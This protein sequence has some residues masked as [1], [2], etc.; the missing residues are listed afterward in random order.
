[1]GFSDSGA[2]RKIC[3]YK[4]ASINKQWRPP[5]SNLT[6]PLEEVEK[7]EQANSKA[8]RRKEMI[9]IRAETNETENRKQQNQRNQKLVLSKDEQIWQS[10]TSLRNEKEKEDSNY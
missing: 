4:N 7:D 3:S 6:L 2:L 5:T 9:M 1:M 10:F 8:C